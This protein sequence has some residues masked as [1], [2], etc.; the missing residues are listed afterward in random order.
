MLKNL[1]YSAFIILISAL[2]FTSCKKKSSD[3]SSPSPVAGFQISIL[4]CYQAPATVTFNNQS[5]NATGYSWSFGDNTTS[6]EASPTHIYSAAGTYTITLTATGDG[7]SNTVSTTIQVSPGYTSAQITSITLAQYPKRNSS[8]NPWDADAGPDVYFKFFKNDTAHLLANYDSLTY[9]NLQ[10]TSLTISLST[11]LLVSSLSDTIY[12][13]AF[14][15]ESTPP[16]SVIGK[17]SEPLVG[18]KLNDYRCSHP[19]T[20]DVSSS[21]DSLKFTIGLQWQ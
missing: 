12:V 9:N 7:G 3:E 8:G 6:T 17:G 16:D 5:T 19:A 18:F 10:A 1:K 13:S 2:V 14:D 4:N 20:I 21:A 15:K 11:P